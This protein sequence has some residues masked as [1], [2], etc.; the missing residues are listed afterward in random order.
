MWLFVIKKQKLKNQKNIQHHGNNS[1]IKYQNGRKSPE[2]ILLN[3]QEYSFLYN[4]VFHPLICE[5]WHFTHMFQ[6]PCMT[7]SFYWLIDWCLTSFCRQIK[8][9][10]MCQRKSKDSERWSKI[11]CDKE[12]QKT[13]G[14]SH[15]AKQTDSA[16]ISNR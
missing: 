16:T 9:N 5:G 2:S 15:K 8:H 13:L 4:N 6:S 3:V 7:A 14:D 1:I 10:C 12:N 11:I